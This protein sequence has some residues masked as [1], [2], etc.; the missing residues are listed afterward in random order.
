MALE[1]LTVRKIDL[2]LDALSK[3]E[4]AFW[5]AKSMT[6]DYRRLESY[7]NKAE[8]DTKAKEDQA[9]LVKASDGTDNK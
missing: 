1:A 6:V 4:V 2:V 5:E 7:A 8:A 3:G 9:L